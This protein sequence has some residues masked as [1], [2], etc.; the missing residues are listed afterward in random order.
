MSDQNLNETSNERGLI[1]GLLYFLNI[2]FTKKWFIIIPTVV[3]GVLLSVFMYISMQLPPEQSPLPNIY[4]A[5]CLILISGN[6]SQSSV[7]SAI[8]AEQPFTNDDTAVDFGVTA[9]GIIR[10][11]GFLDRII[12]KDIFKESFENNL[13]PKASQTDLRQFLSSKIEVSYDPNFR[14]LIISFLDIQP[15]RSKVMAN[16]VVEELDTWFSE[17]G[18]SQRQ[19]YKNLLE[20]KLTEV[21]P[22]IAEYEVQIKNFQKTYGVFSIQDLASFQTGMLSEL[23]SNLI[24]IELQIKNY[25]EFSK[26]E[27]PNLRRLKSE[28]DNLIT[29]IRE[30]E[31]GSSLGDKIPSMNQLPDLALEFNRMNLNLDIQRAIYQH[32]SEQYELVKLS[33]ESENVFNIIEWAET[34]DERDAPSRSLI[35]VA[36]IAI[37]FVLSSLIV[38][39]SYYIRNLVDRIKRKKE[40]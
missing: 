35:I 22:K 10:T 23:R 8:G 34:P 17:Y 28:R 38:L 5:N 20:K 18:L 7:Y 32:L 6:E 27:D 9:L 21:F 13:D 11:R 16:I 15:E 14:T 36:G 33:V 1:E 2:L 29:S 26:I 3:V 40:F 12:K 24:I 4:R 30:I 31:S 25:E 19:K 37:V 39:I